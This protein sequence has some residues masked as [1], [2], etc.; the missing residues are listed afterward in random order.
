MMQYN[1]EVLHV[2]GKCQIST[3]TLSHAPVNSLNTSDIQFT[4]EVEALA[5]STVDQ[6]PATAQRNHRSSE[7][8]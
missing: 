3:D 5:S 1:P 8:R 6:P 2:S 7:K 4:E